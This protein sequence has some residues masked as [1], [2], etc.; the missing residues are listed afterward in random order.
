MSGRKPGGRLAPG[1]RRRHL[2][3]RAPAAPASL[4]V[5]SSDAE[6]A[7]RLGAQRFAKHEA[8][9]RALAPEAALARA[10]SAVDGR[11]HLEGAP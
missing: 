5:L 7:L 10:L 4:V 8:G 11:D 2:A 3:A 1:S 9:G 6:H